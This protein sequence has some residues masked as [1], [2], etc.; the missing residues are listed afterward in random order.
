MSL[1]GLFQEVGSGTASATAADYMD[2]RTAEQIWRSEDSVPSHVPTVLG[3][4]YRMT[5][6]AIYVPRAAIGSN[7]LPG[8]GLWH[9]GAP[10]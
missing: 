5:L 9:V 8:R 4:I 6:L 10:V 1:G 2:K 3:P 7:T